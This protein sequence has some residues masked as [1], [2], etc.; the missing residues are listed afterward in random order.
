LFKITLI[1]LLV[2]FGCQKNHEYYVSPSGNDQHPGTRKQPFATIQKAKQEVRSVLKRNPHSDVTIYLDGGI[3]PL[4]EPL[5]FKPEDSGKGNVRV[6]YTAL[7]GEY[8]FVSG[9]VEINGWKQ[10]KKHM[11]VANLPPI[12]DESW[13]ARELFIEGRRAPRARHPN[14][15]YLRVDRVGADNRTHFYHRTEEF[16]IPEDPAKVE[17]ILLHDWSIT[18]INLKEIDSKEH[19]ITAMDSIGAKVLSFF[20]I[21]NWEPDPRY[22]LEN[23]PEFLDHPYEWYLD[24][25]DQQI[26][27]MLPEGEDPNSLEVIVPYAKK[28]LSLQGTEDHRMGNLSFEGITFAYCAF[29][30]PAEGYAGIQAC[31]MDPRG[32]DENWDVV[33]SAVDVSWAEQVLFNQCSWEHLGGSGLWL[34]AGS[35]NNTVTNC[36]FSDISGNGVM[37][38]EGSSRR[39]DGDPWW[40]GAPEQAAS[41]NRVEHCEISSTGQ[42]FFGAVGIWCG[43]TAH[44]TINNNLIYDLPYT[45]ISAGWH[46]SPE[47]TPCRGLKIEHN[48]IHHIMKILS[49]G[50]GIYVLGL[51]PGGLINGNHIHHVDV[52][53]GRAESNGMFLDEGSTSLTITQNLIHHIARSPLRFHRATTNLVSENILV[54]GEGI[55]PVRYNRTREKDITMK[56]NQVLSVTRAA[57]MQLLKEAI[58]NHPA[59]I[60]EQ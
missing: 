38:G 39:I 3:Y 53:A 45:G 60:S 17:L 47:P 48:H 9:G 23:A 54:C 52:N 22:Y 34:G 21:G 42:Q 29:D 28:L 6:I 51:Q 36:R 14:E 57:D 58:K 35:R 44:T 11:W 56:N 26:H 15:G 50:G 16:P 2:T 55:P 13:S 8:P 41:G 20:T 12:G 33:P 10:T 7:P 4:T 46:W 43:I 5:T 31:H 27:L 30:L 49:D 37:I 19:R 24:K 59:G 32:G 25:T 18:R 40:R 1:I